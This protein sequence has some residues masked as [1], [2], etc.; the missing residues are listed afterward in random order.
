[1]GGACAVC[2]V[3]LMN[4]DAV[5]EACSKVIQSP[6]ALALLLLLGFIYSQVTLRKTVGRVRQELRIALLECKED[7]FLDMKFN[8]SLIAVASRYKTALIGVIGGSRV[9]PPVMHE[10]D[11]E[12]ADLRRR[13]H[14]E[15]GRRRLRVEKA[16]E[17]LERKQERNEEPE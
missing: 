17:A 16:R 4:V 9:A 8:S 12:F 13:M 3:G 11:E 14:D 2:G 7:S 15:T 5:I 6:F 10:I 1:M